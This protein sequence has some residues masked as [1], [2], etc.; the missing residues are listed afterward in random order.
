MRGKV[1]QSKGAT[2]STATARG[3]RRTAPEDA[4]GQAMDRLEVMIARLVTQ[5]AAL[6]AAARLVAQ[7][8]GPVLEIGLGKGRTYSHL[9]SLFPEREIYAFDRDLHALPDATP[10]EG[11]LLLGDFRD[12]LTAMAE[13]LHRPAAFA[14]ADIGS[15]DRDQDAALARAIAGPIVALMAAGGLVLGDRALSHPRLREIDTPKVELPP[16]IAPWRYFTYRV[17][18]A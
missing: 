18:E 2:T 3:P 12:T 1:R 16:G 4:Q 6:D 5:R 13:E 10:P 17:A 9:R 8:D 14:H 11:F 7:L 15:E